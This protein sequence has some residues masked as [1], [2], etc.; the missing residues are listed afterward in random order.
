MESMG[1]SILTDTKRP[2]IQL[3]QYLEMMKPIFLGLIA[4]FF[5]FF[6]P[7]VIFVPIPLALGI[8]LYGRVK[9]TL[10]V[11]LI[12]FLLIFFPF[13][14]A[15]TLYLAGLYA[16]SYVFSVLVGDIIFRNTNP[17]RGLFF[18]GFSFLIVILF[19]LGTYSLFSEQGIEKVLVDSMSKQFSTL[20]AQSSEFLKSGGKDAQLL[21]DLLNN[22]EEVVKKFILWFPSFLVIFVF[23]GLWMTLLVVLKNSFLW[24]RDHLSYSYSLKDLLQLKVPFFFVWPLIFGLILFLGGDNLYSGA[25]ILGGNLLY[26]LSIFYFFQGFGIFNDALTHFKIFGFIRVLSI[27][28]VVTLGLR[29]LVL[30]GVF[31]MWF[32]FRRFL[33]NV[34]KK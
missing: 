27:I 34:N 6:G 9:M 7:F 24:R 13:Q 3:P 12:I 17:V 1:D 5:C 30:V 15:T 10:T 8:L 14:S 22:P 18:Y 21:S 31:D 28:I 26:C 23:G 4:I 2:N 29:F 11:A 20:K 32:N 16:F 25:A 19:L 33:K